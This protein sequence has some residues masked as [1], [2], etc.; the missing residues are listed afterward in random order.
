MRQLKNGQFIDRIFINI[1]LIHNYLKN[2]K[3]RF[4][5]VQDSKILK[6]LKEIYSINNV[7]VFS[8]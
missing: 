7:F 5:V 1:A 3:E 2:L 4:K 8:N 6:F